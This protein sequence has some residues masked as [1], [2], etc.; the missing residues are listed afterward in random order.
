MD[1]QRLIEV[2]GKIRTGDA[3]LWRSE[4]NLHNA[5]TYAVIPILRAGGQ[6]DWMHI[7]RAIVERRI[8]RPNWQ[9]DG[10][11]PEFWTY[12]DSP[13]VMELQREVYVK[14]LHASKHGGV[15][16]EYLKRMMEA[17]HG[18]AVWIPM[19][20]EKAY[21]INPNYQSVIMAQ[22]IV[23]D[24]LDYSVGNLARHSSLLRWMFRVNRSAWECSRLF[25]VVDIL[26]G[27]P[28]K[29]NATPPERVESG[30]YRLDL[31]QLLE[32]DYLGQFRLYN[33]PSG[34]RSTRRGAKPGEH[35]K[36]REQDLDGGID[37][38]L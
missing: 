13:K 22:S 3:I 6:S 34:K 16:V 11:P 4:P 2:S 12:Y 38:V 9:T 30:M 24:G 32:P 21:K 23:Q 18:S 5:D 14:V 35:S 37:Y 33:T 27:F 8:I 15:R 20:H 19:D 17:H 29:S 25:G 28:V 26:C 1:S 31:A 7:S 36:K 10:G